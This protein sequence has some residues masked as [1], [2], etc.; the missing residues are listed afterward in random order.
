MGSR[1]RRDC[2]DVGL[3]VVTL[4]AKEVKRREERPWGRSLQAEG[5]AQAKAQ[6][7]KTRVCGEKGRRPMC[8]LG[9]SRK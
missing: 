8:V 2:T 9:D 3:T 4:Q 7:Q 5:T 6:R 1:E